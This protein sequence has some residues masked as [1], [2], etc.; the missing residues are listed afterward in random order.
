MINKILYRIF[1][2]LSLFGLTCN[3]YYTVIASA[4]LSILFFILVVILVMF[5]LIETNIGTTNHAGYFIKN[6]ISI[7]HREYEVFCYDITIVCRSEFFLSFN[8]LNFKKEQTDDSSNENF[9]TIST[10][11]SDTQRIN[12]NSKRNGFYWCV[13]VVV[14]VSSDGFFVY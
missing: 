5:Y 10:N 3:K 1:V 9:T 2:L 4:V 6:K 7:Y 13:D 14:I 8:I 11:T 12:F